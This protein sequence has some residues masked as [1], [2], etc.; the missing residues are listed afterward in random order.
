MELPAL[1]FTLPNI[2]LPF[3]IPLMMHPPVD[4]FVIALP[5]VV[6]LLELVNLVVKKRAVGV[7]TFFLLLLTAVAAVAAYITGTTDGKEAFDALS[8]AGQADLKAHKLLGTYLIFF[9]V[10]V[11]VFKLLSAMIKRGLMKAL[12]F[13]ILILFV[14]TIVKQGKEGGELVYKYGANVEKAA[15]VTHTT[16]DKKE[17]QAAPKAKEDALKAKTDAVVQKAEEVTAAAKA[18]AHAVTEKVEASAESAKESVVKAAEEVETKI[19][20]SVEDAKKTMENVL[21]PTDEK[22]EKGAQASE[23]K[24]TDTATPTPPS[25]EKATEVKEEESPAE[26]P[27]ETS[28]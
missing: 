10:V 28:K 21:K 13:L 16:V 14:A 12:Y 4:H 5:F 27:S 15:S 2:T 9:S 18:Q 8:Q 20:E 1:P 6:L 17:V 7:T 24:H 26:V 25:S 23:A 3:D 19:S 22:E 11:L